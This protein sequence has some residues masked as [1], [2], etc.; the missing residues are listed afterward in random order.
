M[1][2]F[3]NQPYVSVAAK[4]AKAAR[5]AE[6]MRKA[7]KH[8]APIVI[9]GREIAKTFW[10][11]A[12]CDHIEQLSDFESRLARG[13]SYARNGSVVHLEIKPGRIEAIVAGTRPYKIAIDIDP[14]PPK[15][16][17][18]IKAQCAGR[19]GSL[20][21]LLQGKLSAEVMRVLIDPQKGMFPD[22]DDFRLDCNCPDFARL[23]K[24]L[25][26]CLYGVGSRLDESPELLFTLRGV[27][28]LELLAQVGAA[29]SKMLRDGDRSGSPTVAD[30]DLAQIFGIELSL[31]TP[32][33]SAVT[34][35]P[36]RRKSGVKNT[37]RSR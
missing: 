20:V 18:S 22:A 33:A 3:Y 2:W 16:W 23:C 27:D 13:K 36:R 29:A 8:V 9:E 19:V 32:L 31:Q 7:G 10:G 12:W 28:H 25:A 11:K 34:T 35:K 21:E 15:R 14:L 24:H 37:K 1:S 17:A 26:A 30:A 4:R 5:E 6:K